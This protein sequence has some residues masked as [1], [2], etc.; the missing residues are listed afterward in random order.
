MKKL[1]FSWLLPVFMLVAAIVAGSCSQEEI[2]EPDL[3]SADKQTR[4][5]PSISISCS[6]APKGETETYL[7]LKQTYRF[8]CV[9]NVFVSTSSLGGISKY[10]ILD[11]E[12]SIHSSDG[13]TDGF[14]IVTGIEE[15]GLIF[16]SPTFVKF[17]APG[18]YHVTASTEHNGATYQETT[19]YCVVSRAMS[20]TLPESV[21]LGVPFDLSF[22]F[23]DS[24]YPDP[25]IT[26]SERT[27]Q[28]LERVNTQYAILSNDGQGNYRMRID[29]PGYYMISTGLGGMYS[30]CSNIEVYF[31]PENVRW[32]N[33]IYLTLDPGQGH[34]YKTRI[35]LCDANNNTYTSLPYRV[36]FEAQAI[37]FGKETISAQPYKLDAGVLGQVI[38]P[39]MQQ[40]M[41]VVY[42]WR[43]P[44]IYVKYFDYW[45]LTIP[46]D[47]VGWFRIYDPEDGGIIDPPIDPPGGG[48][49]PDEPIDP[50][51]GVIH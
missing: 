18:Y 47:Q 42:N 2:V 31:R 3:M 22:N 15:P 50:P 51:G 20:M 38:M 46:D 14:E 1:Y 16:D 9:A 29:K 43:P 4:A 21:E 13:S 32:E 5:V 30:A 41:D 49:G 19:T 28:I 48:I 35:F 26:V 8:S 33:D 11:C 37:E 24:S 44:G 7:G 12:L 39:N 10:Q 45:K 25:T 6:P 40:S 36:Y 23:A 17:T 34:Y 27:F